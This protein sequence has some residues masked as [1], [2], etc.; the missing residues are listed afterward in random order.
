MRNIESI[1]LILLISLS[2]STIPIFVNLVL[3][4]AYEGYGLKSL[5]EVIF[6]PILWICFIP[7]SIIFG[8][9]SN[10]VTGVLEQAV[11][12]LALGFIIGVAIVIIRYRKV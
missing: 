6:T 12:M 8:G 2:S 11:G 9:I 3:D 7:T 4:W 1:L 10:G 5:A